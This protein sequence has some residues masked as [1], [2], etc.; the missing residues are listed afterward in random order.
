MTLAFRA[1]DFRRYTAEAC[2]PHPRRW[3]T[4]G[5]LARA[6]DHTTRDS[7]ALQVIDRELVKTADHHVDAGGLMIFMSPQEGKSQRVSRRFPL[8]LLAHDP[9]LRIAIVSYEQ[10]SAVRWGRQ[11]LRDIR[12][13][14]PVVLDVQLM[15]DSSAAGR[16]DTRE[17]GGVYCVGVGG[18][19]TGRPVDVLIIDDP[20]KGREEAESEIIRSRAWDWW[21]N[22]ALTRLASNG[23]AILMMTRWHE[24]DL[25][26]T[27]L[28]R[29]SPMQWRILKIP[30]ISH[31]KGDPLGRPEGAEMPS[32]RDRPPGYFTHRRATTTPYV[33]SSIFDQQPTAAVGNFFRRQAY[34]YWRTVTGQPDPALILGRPHMTGAWIELEGRR[35]DLTD[36]GVWRFA[37]C[38]VAASEKTSADYTVVSVWCIDREGDLILLDRARGQIEMANHFDMAKPLRQRWHYDVLYVEHSFYSKTLVIDARTNGVPVAEVQADTDKVTRAIPAAGRLHSGKCWFPAAAPWLSEWEDELA[39]FPR[40]AHDD[41]VDTFSYAARIAAAHWTPPPPPSR[42][43]PVGPDL[44]RIAAAYGAATGNGNHEVDPMRLPLG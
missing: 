24:M 30:A 36:P 39:S 14:D 7:L 22:V 15:A 38:D 29:P 10:E 28:A 19:L 42:P 41:Q 40:G 4:P 31:G 43:A 12:A 8:W 44:E 3:P 13:A 37:T 26:G 6:L 9:S 20:V 11:I 23:V 27:I 34:R 17:G 32:V 18:A 33:W 16:W 21:E 25:A 1:T 35:V 2:Q 5:A